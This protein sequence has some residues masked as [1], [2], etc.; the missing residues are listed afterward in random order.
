MNG[1]ATTNPEMAFTIDP[2]SG[3][4]NFAL[5]LPSNSASLGFV[6]SIT[7]GGI[8]Q[9][10][11]NFLATYGT[12]RGS[13]IRYEQIL[14]GNPSAANFP[15]IVPGSETV[16]GS[17]MTLPDSVGSLVR[18][19]RVPMSLGEAGPNQ[20][21]I[22]YDAGTIYFSPV[23][24]QK[25]SHALPI[26]LTYKIHFNLPDDIVRGDYT[27]KSLVRIDL[28]MIIYDPET[29]HPHEVDVSDSIKVR[30]AL[31]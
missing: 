23:Y 5:D 13:A 27:T 30:N 19:E 29:G 15:H 2:N 16:W 21:R 14:T 18:Y 1:S 22:D 17:D 25:L 10:N 24:D 12:D 6:T 28:G 9:I 26:T 31:R 8:D 3:R 11:A 7:P 20:Y 4:V